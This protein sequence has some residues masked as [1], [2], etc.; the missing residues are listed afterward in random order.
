[1]PAC[2]D[3]EKVHLKRQ[4]GDLLAVYTWINGERALVIL[5][6]YRPKS[7]WFVV[8]ESAAYLYDDPKYMAKRCPEAVRFMGLEDNTAN[9]VKL[10]TIVNEGLPDLVMMPSEQQHNDR[11]ARELGTMTLR[12]DG[13]VIRQEAFMLPDAAPGAEYVSV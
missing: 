1:M 2:I 10:A 4:H 11:K 5:H 7:P 9:W 13:D 3:L 8:M 12:A 6:A